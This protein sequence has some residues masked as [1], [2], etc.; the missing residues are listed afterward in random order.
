MLIAMAG[1]PATGKS[2]IAERL[3]AELGAVVLS[4]DSVRP[5]LFPP[6]VLDYSREQDDICM[7][8]IFRAAEYILKTFPTQTVI[9]DGRTF[10]R[11]YQ[12]HDLVN[13]G[14]SVGQVPRIIECVCADDVVRA[15]LENDWTH[16][17]HPAGNRTFALYQTLK[18]EAEPIQA[19]RLILDTATTALD[20]CVKRCLDYLVGGQ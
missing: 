3:A 8:A 14:A 18:A 9:I 10:L 7:A 17:E 4:K 2:R 19:E 5:K 16:D 12:V 6:P 11:A 1:L 20:V 13:L 15:R